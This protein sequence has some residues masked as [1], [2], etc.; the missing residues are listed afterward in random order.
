MAAGFLCEYPVILCLA[1]FGSADTDNCLSMH[2]VRFHTWRLQSLYASYIYC[3]S[4]AIFWSLMSLLVADP[5]GRTTNATAPSSPLLKYGIPQL[6]SSPALS[7]GD[8]A[9]A[10]SALQRR[11]DDRVRPLGYRVQLHEE[12]LAVPKLLL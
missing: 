11:L 10:V 12:V 3:I 4:L 1:D 8:V 6:I 9:A 2:P 5:H 7:N